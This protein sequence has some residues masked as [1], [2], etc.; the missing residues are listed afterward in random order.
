[1]VRMILYDIIVDVRSLLTPLWPRLNV[2]VGHNV[3]PY[4]IIL[5]SYAELSI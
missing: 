4:W 1:V 3:L 5:P 2:Y